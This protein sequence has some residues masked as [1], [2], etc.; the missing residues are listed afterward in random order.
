[1]REV[2]VRIVRVRGFWGYYLP[3]DVM[4][5]FSMLYELVEWGVAVCFGGD[6]AQNYVGAQ[7]DVWD[8]QKDM[9]LASL[10]GLTTMTVTALINWCFGRRGFNSKPPGSGPLGEARIAEML[11]KPLP[12]PLKTQ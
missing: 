1:V 6:L 8:A 7:G 3:L 2:F 10:G 4:M 11:K 5:S 12:A 9:A